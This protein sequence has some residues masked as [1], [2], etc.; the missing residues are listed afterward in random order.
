LEF[1]GFEGGA[2]V[3]AVQMGV[4]EVAGEISGLVY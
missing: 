4:D 2:E 1:S 3:D